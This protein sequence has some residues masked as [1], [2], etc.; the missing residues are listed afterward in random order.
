MTKEKRIAIKKAEITNNCPECFNQELELTFYQKHTYNPFFHRTTPEVTYEIKCKKCHSIIYPVDWTTD[1]ERVF[2]Y[3]NKLV[4][5]DRPSVRF[6]TLFFGLLI[7]ILGVIGTVFYLH[8][9]NLI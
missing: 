4:R 5:P 1:I 6:T 9:E 3:Y 7:L 8:L 2:D